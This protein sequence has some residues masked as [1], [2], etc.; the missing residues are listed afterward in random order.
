MDVK[1]IG[2]FIAEQRRLKQLTQ[3][4]LGAA[5]G[6]SDKTVSKWECGYGLPDIS[7]ITPLCA[8]L[9]TTGTG[10]LS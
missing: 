7:M 5:L 4:Q 8:E 9:E 10:R 2:A 6:I 3:K 1:K